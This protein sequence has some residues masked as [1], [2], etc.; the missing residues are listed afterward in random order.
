MGEGMRVMI[1]RGTHSTAEGADDDE[2]VILRRSRRVPGAGLWRG[3]STRLL[4]LFAVPKTNN[5][6]AHHTSIQPLITVERRRE[7][8]TCRSFTASFYCWQIRQEDAA[9]SEIGE[10]I[11][12]G[13][14]GR[15][16]N[17]GS[18]Q[19]S[20]ELPFLSDLS[21]CWILPYHSIDRS[22]VQYLS[23]SYG[24]CCGPWGVRYRHSLGDGR[25]SSGCVASFYFSCFS[26][27]R[28]VR[29]YLR[30]FGGVQNESTQRRDADN[31]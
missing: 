6:P 7:R 31:P 13:T 4:L 18:A 15:P 29:K 27:I 16:G 26:E 1:C 11:I 22:T 3:G 25:Y 9:R 2:V 30:C 28:K 5:Q 24:S 23:S 17:T 19:S 21:F 12:F 8:T 20:S 14:L 10:F